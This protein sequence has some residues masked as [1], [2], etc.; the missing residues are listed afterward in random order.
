MIT[1][2]SL[3]APVTTDQIELRWLDQL[4]ALGLP[5]KSWRKGGSLR[6]ILRVLAGSYAGFTQS[7]SGFIYAGFIETASGGWLTLL[8]YYVYGVS[9][10]VATFATGS[11][12]LTNAGGGVFVVPASTYQI[13][14]AITGKVYTNQAAFTLN[15]ASTITIP[16]QAVELGTLSNALPGTITAPITILPGVTA[17]NPVAVSGSDDEKDADLRQ[18][19]KD[20]LA[21]IG[22]KGPRGAYRFAAQSAVRGDGSPVNVNRISVS[23]QSSTGIVTIYVASVAGAPTTSDLPFITASIETLA[24]PDTDTVVLNAATPIPLTR[25]LTVWARRTDGV[26]ATTLASLVQSALLD[27]V[28][29][30]PIGGLPKPPGTQGYLYATAIEGVAKSAHPSVFAVDGVGSDLLMAAG[31]VVTLAT[32]ITVNI[33]DVK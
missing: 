16:I 5:A 2:D 14:H 30:Y 7:I 12:Q 18:R 15:P 8:A 17:T 13:A 21:I 10:I 20:R 3:L 27:Y 33:V 6:T 28:T 31:T 32:T 29:T 23:P 24:R 9:R 19:S 26:D 1:V 4:Q 25:A 22:G 11:M